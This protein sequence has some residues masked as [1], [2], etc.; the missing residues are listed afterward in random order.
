M[1]FGRSKKVLF[2]CLKERIWKKIQGWK[3]RLMLRV[4]KEVLIKTVVQ[5]IPSYMMSIFSILENKIDDIQ[6]MMA[7]I[8]WDSSRE[9]RK[10]Y[11]H[12]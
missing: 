7:H 11:W 12:S 3:E 4:G 6:S 2:S 8:W 9:A 10:T 1:I 5:A